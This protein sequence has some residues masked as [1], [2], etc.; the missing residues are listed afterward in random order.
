ML[1]VYQI[2][3][4]NWKYI[5]IGL[6]A[7][8]VTTYI[9][10]YIKGKND[11]KKEVASLTIENT[12]LKS[13]NEQLTSIINK[14]SKLSEV[15]DNQFKNTETLIYKQNIIKERI[16]DYKDTNHPF[17][18]IKLLDNARLLRDYQNSHEDGKN[19]NK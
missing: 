18:D 7:F 10:L 15:K 2:L 17:D 13:E 14:N 16:N 8:G 5:L 9:G 11:L 19:T 12:S 4:A 6:L 1:I 3:K